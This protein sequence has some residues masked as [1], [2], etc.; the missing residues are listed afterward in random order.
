MMTKA[1]GCSEVAGPSH[2]LRNYFCNSNRERTL[3]TRSL[4]VANSNRRLERLRDGGNG[5][6][7]RIGFHQVRDFFFMKHL[8]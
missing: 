1:V 6:V 3:S 2:F 8:V 4:W 7:R 5:A